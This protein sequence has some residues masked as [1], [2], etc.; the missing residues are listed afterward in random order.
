MVSLDDLL[1]EMLRCRASDL[2]ISVDVAAQLRINHELNAYGDPLDINTVTELVGAAMGPDRFLEYCRLKE[3][4][5]ALVRPF[6]RFRVSG[7]WQRELPGMVIR[8]IRTDI[9]TI[10]ELGLP[11]LVGELAM[12]RKGLI[13]VVGATGS[14]K[15]TTLAAMLGYRNQY[16]Q[17]HI[18]TVEDPIEFIHPN[19]RCLITQR[20]V[21]MDTESYEIALKNA[22]RQAP[23]VIQVGEIRARDTLQHAVSFSETGHLCIA[24]LHANNASQALERMVH[25]I[26]ESSRE[27]F[28]FDLSNNLRAIIGQQLVPGIV[29]GKRLLVHEI[30]I[31]TPRVTDLLRKNQLFELREVMAR[32]SEIGMCTFDQSLYELY[33]RGLISYT[34]AIHYAES[35]NDLRLQIRSNGDEDFSQNTFDNV[36]VDLG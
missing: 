28:L 30:L 17:A 20:E 15:T 34:D 6:G 14:G 9:P 11:P 16:D 35:A 22:L 36:T 2:Y 4:N 7:F 18:L 27:A 25:M 8:H 31:N 1:Q 29:Q 33:R 24:T 32:N 13:L 26:P 3:G 5:M 12:T 10:D 21:G 19:K 23:D